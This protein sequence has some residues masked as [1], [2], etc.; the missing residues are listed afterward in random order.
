MKI[1]IICLFYKPKDWRLRNATD[2]LCL[3][4]SVLFRPHYTDVETG[5]GPMFFYE[6]Q[7]PPEPLPMG[8][9]FETCPCSKPITWDNFIGQNEARSLFFIFDVSVK[10]YAVGRNC[11]VTPSTLTCQWWTS[12]PQFVFNSSII[13]RVLFSVYLCST[14]ANSSLFSSLC[15]H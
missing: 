2:Q 7:M 11:V 13:L 3:P 14:H 5:L 12:N 10:H 8:N 15:W 6:T 4:G 9:L 1:F